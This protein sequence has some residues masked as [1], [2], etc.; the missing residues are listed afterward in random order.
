MLLSLSVS[1]K[2]PG[3]LTC[4]VVKARLQFHIVKEADHSYAAALHNRTSGHIM[5][6]SLR[7][8]VSI[9]STDKLTCQV[10]KPKLQFHVVKG[11]DLY[12]AAALHN[13]AS[14]HMMQ[15]CH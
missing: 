8:S 6:L 11:A 13:R 4:Q 10:L 2:G 3:K 14:G 9:I 12:V 5:Q 15:L 7:L 1:I